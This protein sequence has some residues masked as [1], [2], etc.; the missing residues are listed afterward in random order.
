[1]EITTKEALAQLK[2]E[3]INEMFGGGDCSPDLDKSVTKQGTYQQSSGTF[4]YTVE[5]DGWLTNISSFPSEN[6][7]SIWE[8]DGYNVIKVQVIS[9]QTSSSGGAYTTFRIVTSLPFPLKKGSVVR[10]FVA[11]QKEMKFRFAPCRGNV[12]KTN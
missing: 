9:V 8:V 2:Q 12:N 11:S 1:M 4:E 5:E 10:C 7:S 3:L 6:T